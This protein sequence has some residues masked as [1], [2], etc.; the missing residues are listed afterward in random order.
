MIS[1]QVICLSA[2]QNPHF[3]MSMLEAGASG[4]LVKT[5]SARELIAAV[6]TVVS[7]Q[8]YLSPSITKDFVTHNVQG[9]NGNGSQPSNELTSRELEV[10]QLIAQGLHTSEIARHLCISPKTV[11]VH[12]HR[13]MD[14][15]GLDTPVALV[16]H[17]LHQGLVEPLDSVH[18]A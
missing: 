15:L 7:G 17:A 16:R 1:E 12:R 2:H 13:I 3:I 10:L 14:K 11:L 4:Y 5:I 8:A 18:W 9:K 6:R